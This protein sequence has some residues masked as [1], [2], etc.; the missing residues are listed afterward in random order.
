MAST[1]NSA[2]IRL[3]LR[4]IP[5]T[6]VHIY[7]PK[8]S[9]HIKINIFT[10]KK[11]KKKTIRIN[12]FIDQKKRTR[13]PT[14]TWRQ[15]GD[16]RPQTASSW[17]FFVR[18]HLLL[19]IHWGDALSGWRRMRPSFLTKLPFSLWHFN[20]LSFTP[21]H[22]ERRVARSASADS[23]PLSS[24]IQK[25]TFSNNTDKKKKKGLLGEIVSFIRMSLF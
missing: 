4:Y 7:S 13:T 22:S 6:P 21:A 1:H 2:Q 17:C 19:W 15:E 11:G 14:Q 12:N 3:G 24:W 10:Q 9:L 5:H 18:S 16:S 8:G 25:E 23:L 20:S